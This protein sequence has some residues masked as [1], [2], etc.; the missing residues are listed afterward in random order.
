MIGSNGFKERARKVAKRYFENIGYEYEGE[1][2]EQLVHRDGDEIAFVTVKARTTSRRFPDTVLNRDRVEEEAISFL[3]EKTESS[4]CPFRFDICSILQLG[5]GK[6]VIRHE[7][8]AGCTEKR[9]RCL[10]GHDE[11]HDAMDE[12]RNLYGDCGIEAVERFADILST[13]REHDAKASIASSNHPT[14][15]GNRWLNSETGAA[16]APKDGVTADAIVDTLTAE[17]ELS[18]KMR[19]YC[20]EIGNVDSAKMF[21]CE[22]AFAER[23]LALVADDGGRKG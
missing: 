7:T 10:A 21:E 18:R 5:D 11:L 9:N 8:N 22:L 4:E 17:A 15:V 20:K 3:A 2:G 19:D 1:A 16:M 23:V 14:A 13:D 6:A 12:Y